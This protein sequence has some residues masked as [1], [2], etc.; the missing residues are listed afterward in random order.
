MRKAGRVPPPVHLNAR[1]LGWRLRELI[2]LIEETARH[3]PK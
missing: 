1:K 3:A 2:A